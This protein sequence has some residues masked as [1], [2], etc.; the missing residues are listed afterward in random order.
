[1]MNSY[2]YVNLQ[3]NTLKTKG[4]TDADKEHHRF[5]EQVF[6]YTNITIFVQLIYNYSKVSIKP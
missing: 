1:M 5:R 3:Q 4:V 2:N 6:Q